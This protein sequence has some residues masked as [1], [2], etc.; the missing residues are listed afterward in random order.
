M[1][2]NIGFAIA[3][4]MFA[5]SCS[6]PDPFAQ[7]EIGKKRIELYQSQ[8][9]EDAILHPDR[10][11]SFEALLGDVAFELTRGMDAD[12]AIQTFVADG[13]S[14]FGPTCV[15]K[16]TVRETLFP[17]GVPPVSL[18]SMCIRQPGPRRT[19]EEHY[20]VTLLNRRIQ[21]RTDISSQALSR[22]VPMIE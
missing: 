3:V 9:V 20:E 11:T 15:W 4:L 14:C 21:D 19:F 2:M 5:A 18:V 1:R 10:D 8:T 22:T 16:Y 12:R 13:A 7:T 17:C 6:T